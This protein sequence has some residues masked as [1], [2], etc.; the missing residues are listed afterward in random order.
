MTVETLVVTPEIRIVFPQEFGVERF[1]GQEEQVSAL[2]V[3]EPGDRLESIAD[4]VL[5]ARVAMYY[6]FPVE[7]MRNMMISRPQEGAILIGAKFTYG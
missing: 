7:E 1:S 2:N 6:D 5:L 4:D 3:L